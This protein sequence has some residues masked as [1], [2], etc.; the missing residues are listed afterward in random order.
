MHEKVQENAEEIGQLF[1]EVS[2]IY[3]G[4]KICNDSTRIIRKYADKIYELSDWHIQLEMYL[5]DTN[6]ESGKYKITARCD[7]SEDK[8]E[9]QKYWK[10]IK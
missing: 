1:N 8:A 10:Q 6:S 2:E 4:Q 9:I 5:S 3:N 7:D